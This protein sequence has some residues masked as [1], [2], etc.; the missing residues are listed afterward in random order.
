MTD[1][2]LLAGAVFLSAAGDLLALVTL[3]L[4][5]HDL[6]G[7]PLAVSALFAATMVPVVAIA[8]VAGQLVDRVET[9]RLLAVSSLLAATVAVAL[10]FASDLA[11]I[12]ALTALLAGIGAVGQ[13]AEF[14]LVPH[15]AAPRGLGRANGV[16]EA[17]RCAGF[18]VGPTVAGVIVAFGGERLALLVNAGSFLAIAA[19]A[20][21][22]RARRPPA[23]SPIPQ[24]ARDGAA[25][26]WRDPVL[27]VILLVNI[28]A[29][30]FISAS[31]T[32][33]VFY[34]KEVLGAGDAAYAGIV[35]VWMAAMV[36]GATGLA[37][38]L[39][40]RRA[41]TLALVALAFQGAG[42]AAQTAWAILPAALAGYAVGGLGHGVKNT[43]LRLV[44][45]QRVPGRLHGRAYAAYNAARNAAEL[46]ALAAGGLLVA[47]TGPSAALLIAGLVPVA[48]AA[49]GL[50][51]LN[52]RLPAIE[53]LEDP[54][55]DYGR[56]LVDQEVADP[57]EQ[58][59]A[60]IVGVVLPAAEERG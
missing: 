6:T 30:L 7:D 22:M 23:A 3:A 38:S 10:A 25:H 19:A 42:M 49:A 8:P 54:G 58:L 16:L 18:A 12:L 33:E 17:A 20:A 29:L 60:E 26:L 5:V 57:V 56:L 48:L 9:V 51:V 15:I 53:E 24:R 59:E 28:A 2:R 46:V 21:L 47:A 14:A 39:P 50:A 40:G 37:G 34:V 31:L 1:L 27:R 45:Q 55:A 44:I 35:G 11:A 43:L 36:A 4:L 41:A 32:I 13:P 52:P